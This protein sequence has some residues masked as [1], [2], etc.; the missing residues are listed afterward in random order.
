[1][2]K[3]HCI[4][5]FLERGSYELELLFCVEASVDDNLHTNM[6]WLPSLL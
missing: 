2:I 3:S 5:L 1:M 6:L 4:S